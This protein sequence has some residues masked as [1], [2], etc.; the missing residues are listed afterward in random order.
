MNN[1]NLNLYENNFIQPIIEPETI[2]APT[3]GADILIERLW[4]EQGFTAILVTHDVSE[5]V[6]LADRIIL[7]DQG[8]IAQN[9]QVNLPRPRKKS[10]AFAQL[11]QLVLDAVLAT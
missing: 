8:H 11:E 9:F 5:A 2:N 10:I 3:N 6:Q 7:L 4:K 1:L